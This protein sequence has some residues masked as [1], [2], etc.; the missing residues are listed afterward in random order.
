MKTLYMHSRRAQRGFTLI[1]SMVAI[2]VVMVLMAIAIPSY[3]DA[4]YRSQLRAAAN[5]LVTTAHFARSEAIKRNAPVTMCMS[6][7]GEHC[8]ASGS[9]EQGWIVRSDVTLRRQSSTPSGV[10]ISAGGLVNVTFQ[11]TGADA[12]PV[13]FRVCRVSSESGREE[14]LVTIDATGRPSVRKTVSSACS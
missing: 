11:P 3:R 2:A 12:T 13:S 7:D 10:R 8:T 9:W 5:D 14:R 6:S 1:E 4:S